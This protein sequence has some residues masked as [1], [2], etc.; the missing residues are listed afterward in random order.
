MYILGV[1]ISHNPSLCLLK[2]GEVE[3]YT[4]VERHTRKKDCLIDNTFDIK[5][6]VDHPVDHVAIASY[7][8]QFDAERIEQVTKG[9]EY[10]E[11]HYD[12]HTHHKYHAANAFYDSGF[13]EANAIV[14]DGFG[15]TPREGYYHRE[16]ESCYRCTYNDI[17]PQKKHY[18]CCDLS[19]NRPPIFE[20]DSI[21]SDSCSPGFM[22]STAANRFGMNA[23][24]DA[25]KVMGMA[26]YGNITDDTPWYHDD[27][28]SNEQYLKE[29]TAADTFEKQLD[30]AAKLQQETRKHTI[31]YIH[32]IIEKFP[33]DNLV[34][35]GGY[36]LN[37]VN[38][39]HCREEFPSLNLYIDPIAHDGGTALGFAKMLWYNTTEDTTIRPLETLYLGPNK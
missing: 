32:D 18:S 24:R 36:F 10:G 20:E 14:I 38:N 27:V 23:G 33:C 13:E 30:F 25:G 1:N 17:T 9:L 29:L 6:Y 39:Y 15:A 11:L 28:L 7:G 2:D 37:C 21:F 5:Y 34:L 8:G 22:F 35:S 31:S 19:L 4:E 16:I 12:A 3:W 26:A